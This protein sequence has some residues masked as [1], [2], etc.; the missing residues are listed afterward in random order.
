[1]K[2]NAN[3][4]LLSSLVWIDSGVVASQHWTHFLISAGSA[5]Y[6]IWLG[7]L[8]VIKCQAML[9]NHNA[10]VNSHQRWKQ[11]RICV[12]FHLWCELTSTMSTIK[13]R[14][15]TALF[16]IFLETNKRHDLTWPRP[17]IDWFVYFLF[18]VLSQ[19]PSAKIAIAKITTGSLWFTS[20]VLESNGTNCP[21]KVD[22][23]FRPVYDV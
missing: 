17:P 7:R 15:I 6:Q 22:K 19:S 11:T 2:A 4:R 16:G 23:C 5:F 20:L 3:S 10:R 12:C 9:W 18:P 13:L 1:M 8:T 14:G 21:K